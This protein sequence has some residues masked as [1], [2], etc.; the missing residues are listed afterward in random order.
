MTAVEELGAYERATFANLLATHVAATPDRVA[1]YLDDSPLTWAELEA[2][3]VSAANALL[4]IGVAPGNAVALFSAGCPE[5]LAVWLATPRI[6]ALS[7]PTNI[8]FKGDFLAHQ[9]RDAGVVAILV[10]GP[11]LEHVLAVADAC[12]GLRTIFLLGEQPAEL[13]HVPATLTIRP[14][15]DLAG[16]DRTTVAGGAP[17]RWNEPATLMYTSGTTGP[18]KG[19]MLTQHC[20]VASGR[21]VAESGGWGADDVLYGAVPLFHGSG[22]LGL[23]LPTLINGSQ[24]VI[25]NQ[26]SVSGCWDR[27]RLYGATGFM[28]VGPMLMML[29]G[30]PPSD[31]DAKL[32]IKV[33]LIAPIPAPL[34]HAIEARYGLQLITIYGMTE[35]QPM[36]VLGVNDTAVPGSAGKASPNFEV[37]VVDEHDLDVPVGEIGQI[38]CRPRYPHVMFEGYFG[39]PEATAAQTK[40][41]WFHTGD[42]ARIDAGGNLFFVDRIKDAIRRRGENISSFEVEMVLMS[43][44]SIAEVAA[45]PVPSP[46]GE[47]DVKLCVILKPDNHLTHADLMDFCVEK[48]PRFALPRYIEFVSVLPKNATGRVQ[49]FKLRETAQNDATWDV[50]AVGYQI[51]R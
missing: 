22:I 36:T 33:G 38:V 23:V 51:K 19:A 42:A 50:Q 28:A 8:M 34:H 39:R 18:S 44:G 1:Y 32:P 15:S 16:H 31:E 43:Q 11:R 7:V 2:S 26:F 49:K 45:L 10:D 46:L 24:S 41:L 14:A 13:N 25:D 30:L 3:T 48:L 21:V 35:A 6:G 5:W 12:P 29:W 27:V 47:D 9:L 4:S 20:L 37:R 40:N 17:L